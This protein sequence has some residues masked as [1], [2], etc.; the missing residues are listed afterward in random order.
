[1]KSLHT[2]AF[3]VLA[4]ATLCADTVWTTVEEDGRVSALLNGKTVLAW[5]KEPLSA[6]KGGEK[7]A[8][9]NFIHPLATPS[10]FVCTELQPGDHMHHFGLWWPWKFVDVDGKRHNTWEIQNGGGAHVAGSA[11]VLEKGPDSLKWRLSSHVETRGPDQDPRVVIR[12]TTDLAMSLIDGQTIAIDMDIKQSATDAKVVI[13]RNHY[14]GLGFRGNPEW[15]DKTSRLVTSEGMDRETGNGTPIRWVLVTG[16]RP[17]GKASVLLMSAAATTGEPERVRVWNAKM[18]SGHHFV[19]I[20][21]VAE[22]NL[23]LDDD[24]PAVSMRRYRIITSDR[25]LDAEEAEK[26]WKSWLGR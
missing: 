24:H 21:P 15:N 1:M 10:G 26:L 25:E 2:V 19:N 22:K 4:A 6:P 23:P 8:G 16:D 3:A 13:G 18:H 14:S 20:N 11:E 5:Q 7:F 9:S 17:G 12:E